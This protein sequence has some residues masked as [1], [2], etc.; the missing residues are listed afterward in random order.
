MPFSNT[1]Q[2]YLPLMSIQKAT[3]KFKE[4]CEKNNVLPDFI[5]SVIEREII[6]SRYFA[7]TLYIH[8]QMFNSWLEEHKSKEGRTF[9]KEGYL[10]QIDVRKQ[11]ELTDKY[12]Y[13]SEKD[14]KVLFENELL[15]KVIPC[16]KG[17][18]YILETNLDQFYEQ[19]KLF[20]HIDIVNIVH[21]YIKDNIGSVPEN[22]LEAVGF[23]IES[24]YSLINQGYIKPIYFSDNKANNSYLTTEAEVDNCM[25]K[26]I[27]IIEKNVK[28][29]KERQIVEGFNFRLNDA[30]KQKAFLVNRLKPFSPPTK[31]QRSKYRKKLQDKF[32]VVTELKTFLSNEIENIDI[33]TDLKEFMSQLKSIIPYGYHSKIYPDMSKL[34]KNKVKISFD[35]QIELYEEAL[36]D[37]RKIF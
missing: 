21:N 30:I 16:E 26:L 18:D 8:P 6:Q 22:L 10:D 11:F 28:A 5:E 24:N 32:N 31:K 20:C 12:Y 27:P 17:K 34:H 2:D 37:E 15:G 25:A 1:V 4:N 7:N 33:N 29:K 35:K 13:F 14:I 36:L 3:D 23:D 9:Q 19:D